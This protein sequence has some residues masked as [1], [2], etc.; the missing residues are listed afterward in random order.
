[1]GGRERGRDCG[2]VFGIVWFESFTSIL[3]VCEGSGENVPLSVLTRDFVARQCDKYQNTMCWRI[4]LSGR[5]N[6]Q[7]VQVYPRTY[8]SPVVHRRL[9]ADGQSGF[10]QWF[11][12]MSL[13]NF[14]SV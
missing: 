2:R 6:L 1:M 12:S 7:E 8:R 14:N 10:L 11:M 13:V 3:C 4:H 5:V 9:Q